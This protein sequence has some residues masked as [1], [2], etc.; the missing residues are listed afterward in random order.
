MPSRRDL[1]YLQSE[2]L[3]R[4]LAQKSYADYLAYVHGAMWKTTRMST[5]IANEV[6]KFLE[7]DTGHAYDV[8]VIETPPQHGK[9][10]TVT[11]T[12]PSWYLG[13]N[14]MNSVI[15]ASY[16]KDFAD[17]FCRRNKEKIRAVG[18]DLFGI[19]IGDINRADEFELDNGRGH[20]LS[21]GVMSGITGNP[22]NLILIDDPVKNMQEADSPTYR[23]NLWEEWQATLKSRLAA[24]SKVI[25]I[26]TPWHEDDLAARVL[27]SEEN[28]SLIRLPI[29][30]EENDPLGRAPGEALCPELGKDDKWLAD[31]KKSYIGD[32]AGGIRAWTALYKCSPRIEGGNLV[33]RDW[34]RFY[35]TND[36]TLMFGSELIS[37]DAAFK[38]ADTNDYVSIQVWGKRKN[39]YYLEYCMNKHL[40][41]PETVDAIR[42]LKRLFPRAKQILIED[43]ANGSAIIST[44]QHD[45]DMFVIPI[46]PQGGKV[47][48][49]NAVSAAIESGHVYLPAPDQAPW[50]ADFIDQFTAF[51]NAAHDDMVDAASQALNRMI[52]FTGEYEEYKPTEDELATKREEDQFNDPNILFNPYSTGISSLM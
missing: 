43:K 52:Y 39:D 30:A 9:S 26:M 32:A 15:I 31:F 5:Y 6:Q 24:K 23:S 36:A 35:D 8:L 11:E 20:L 47:A 46:N 7:T 34:W 50:V 12:L 49:V 40:D 22:A 48:R 25:I 51:P 27:S 38:N 14:P 18:A 42:T 17:K 45:P 21:R 3:R 13:K 37:V 33:R 4:M 41:F 2:M 1:D 10:M 16:N 19:T 44:L 28:V 29:E